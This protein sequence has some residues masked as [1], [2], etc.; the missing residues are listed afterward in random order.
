RQARSMHGTRNL[1][2]YNLLNPPAGNASRAAGAGLLATGAKGLA[3][4]GGGY[5]AARTA[6]Q[7]F[8]DYADVE[9]RLTRIMITAEATRREMDGVLGDL[10]GLANRTATPLDKVVGG[11]DTLVQQGRNLKDSLAFLPAVVRSAQASGA[12]VDDIAKTADAIS[13]HLKVGA[14]EMQTAFDILQAG[15]KAGQFELK[16]MARYLPSMLPAAK[17]LGIT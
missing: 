1:G 5:L 2:R 15:G 17:A 16:D 7:G 10:E 12:E 13:T 6:G 4:V 9:R 11:L 3:V 8:K 14:S